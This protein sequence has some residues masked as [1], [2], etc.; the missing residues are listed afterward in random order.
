[1]EEMES[2]QTLI[3]YFELNDGEIFGIQQVD[4]ETKEVLDQILLERQ[5]AI[6][7]AQDIFRMFGANV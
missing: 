1:M 2:I 5:V 4:P 3:E 6:E 7:M